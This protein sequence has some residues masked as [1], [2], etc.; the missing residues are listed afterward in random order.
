VSERLLRYYP[1]YK[2][3]SQPGFG[4]T[5]LLIA[6]SDCEAIGLMIRCTIFQQLA[7]KIRISGVNGM[8]NLLI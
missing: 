3:G 2:G 4:I 6:S 7:E 8:Q 1:F 5:Q